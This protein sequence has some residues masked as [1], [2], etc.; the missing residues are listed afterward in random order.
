[1]HHRCVAGAVCKLIIRKHE[2]RAHHSAITPLPTDRSGEIDRY[3]YH[4][5]I[6]HISSNVCLSN[7]SFSYEH[8]ISLLHTKAA[9]FL[10][11]L[12][13]FTIIEIIHIYLFLIADK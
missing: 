13:G 12:I 6:E 5:M 11:F 10:S 2:A 8:I 7:Q 4:V 1:M 3:V 9:S